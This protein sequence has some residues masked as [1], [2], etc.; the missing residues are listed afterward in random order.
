[1]TAVCFIFK[2]AAREAY[3]RVRNETESKSK[4]ELEETINGLKVSVTSLHLCMTVLGTIVFT[5]SF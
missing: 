4:K 3:D 1:M 2:A 5:A